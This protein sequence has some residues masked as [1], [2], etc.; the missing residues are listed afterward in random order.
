MLSPTGHNAS[1]PALSLL[2][3]ISLL[4]DLS[5]WEKGGGKPALGCPPGQPTAI[6]APARRWEVVPQA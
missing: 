2:T 4:C 6:S 5:R 1:P 3:L